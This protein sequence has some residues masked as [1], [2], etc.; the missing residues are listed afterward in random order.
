M[1]AEDESFASPGRTGETEAV[2]EPHR[3][4]DPPRRG[5]AMPAVWLTAI[6]LM[7]LLIVGFLIAWTAG[8]T[9]VG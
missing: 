7:V 5:Y 9:D 4:N 2:N 6:G 3:D 1:N 8:L